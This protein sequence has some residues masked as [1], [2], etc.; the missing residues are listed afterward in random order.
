[1]LPRDR[2]A[3]RLRLAAQIAVLAIAYWI[4]ARLSLDFALVHGQVTPVWPPSGLAVFVL[5]R[6]GLR[7]AP[8][9]FLGAL[10]ANLPMGPTPEGAAAIALGDTLAPMFASELLKLARFDFRFLRLRDAS[11][12]IAAALVGMCV[13]A[14]FGTSVLMLAGV[15][16]ESS[17][18]AT[19]IV[20]WTGDAMGVLLVTPFL[21]SLLPSQDAPRLT[22][23]RAI[24][25]VALLIATGVVTFIL[26]ETRL[27][28]EY[29]VFP[30][31]ML[32]AWR[33]RLR[34]AAP[35]AMLASGVAIWSALQGI[36]PFG[37]ESLPQKMVTLQAFNV[38]VAVTSY[39]LAAYVA[40]RKRQQEMSLELAA[41]TAASDAKSAFLNIAAHEL[42]TPISV[43]NG[44]LSMLADGSLGEPPDQWLR[45]LG[46]L[47]EKT[48]ELEKIVEDLL[49][50]SRIEA[51]RLRLN[52]DVFDLRMAVEAAVARARPRAELMSATIETRLGPKHVM[53]EAD[54]ARI[55]R[56]ID[57][58][59]NNAL[60]YSERPAHVKVDFEVD[61]EVAAIRVEDNGVGIAADQ[62]EAVFE[63]FQR[64]E[65]R[66]LDQTP[67]VGLGLFISR[68]V[69]ERHGGRLCIARSAPGEGSVFELTLPVVVSGD[70]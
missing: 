53:V 67:G 56:V 52:K 7:F 5:F 66:V 2:N 34:G 41:A 10:A 26:F 64:R 15:V 69:A 18:W 35:A 50:A 16:G 24:E 4:A 31:I 54:E 1:L 23:R 58:L 22:W 45:P 49:D 29:L 6:F 14:T 13:S 47:A 70:G 33:F 37:G 8:G 57:N 63:R 43:L 19:W 61:S 39:V 38:S 3:D 60:S 44:Y 46:V 28:L 42:R 40:A 12:M 27:R 62:H 9:V 48:D 21:F 65:P 32:S 20:W 11:E 36:G 25:L 30:L 17:F 51:D 68:Q 55:G 59:I